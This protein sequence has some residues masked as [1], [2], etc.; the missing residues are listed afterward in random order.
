MPWHCHVFTPKH[1]RSYRGH[2][3]A[4]P[5]QTRIVA[6]VYPLYQWLS[7]LNDD[8]MKASTRPPQGIFHCIILPLHPGIPSY[9]V[10]L[11]EKNE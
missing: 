9:V 3:G 10:D 7:R 6:T 8:I 4:V 1:P 2:G 5:S 11:K